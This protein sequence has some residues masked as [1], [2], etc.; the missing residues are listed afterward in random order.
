MDCISTKMHPLAKPKFSPHGWHTP[1]RNTHHPLLCLLVWK[2]KN[3]YQNIYW[4]HLPA[5]LYYYFILFITL[6]QLV[7]LCLNLVYYLRKIYF[8][9]LVNFIFSCTDLLKFAKAI[10][11]H[12]RKAIKFSREY[13]IHIAVLGHRRI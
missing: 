3:C 12:I 8:F 1:V 11:N 13:Y 2:Y 5:L 10:L 6:L 7:S 4:Q 9:R